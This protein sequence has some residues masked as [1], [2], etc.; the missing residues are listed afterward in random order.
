MLTNCVLRAL[1]R[2]PVGKGV[3]HLVLEGSSS[4]FLCLD[5]LFDFAMEASPLM[6]PDLRVVSCDS[7]D[8]QTLVYVAAHVCY[9]NTMRQRAGFERLDVLRD[10]VRFRLRS[11]D[12]Y[13]TSI[14]CYRRAIRRC[15]KHC[16]CQ[17]VHRFR[18]H[19]ARTGHFMV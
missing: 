3:R 9:A 16:I 4:A 10:G 17:F 19:C 11:R 12:L 15:N 6:H 13:S 1:V 14:V 5:F 18:L 2:R 7:A 8:F